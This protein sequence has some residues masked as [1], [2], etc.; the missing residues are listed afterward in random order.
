M[1]RTAELAADGDEDGITKESVAESTPRSTTTD[2]DLHFDW[3]Q[4]YDEVVV[5]FPI[6]AHVKSRDVRC[7]FNTHSISVSV[8]SKEL[9]HG[10]LYQ[11]MHPDDCVWELGELPTA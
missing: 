8:G 5:E 3:T 11:A 10:D 2:G 1:S 4:T 9:L 6:E 7:K